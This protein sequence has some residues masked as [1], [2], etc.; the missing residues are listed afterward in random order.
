[1]AALLVAVAVTAVMG[2][3]RALGQADV[4]VAR[5]Q[6]LQRLVTAKANEVLASTD[7]SSFGDGG[8]FTDAGYPDITWTIDVQTSGATDVD[9]VTVAATLDNDEQFLTFLQYVRPLTAVSE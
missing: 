5:N 1:M 4:K 6:L 3:L 2:G 9:E 7:P 8:D